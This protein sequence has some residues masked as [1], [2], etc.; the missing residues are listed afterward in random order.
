MTVTVR[1]FAL[2]GEEAGASSEVVE[3]SART[4]HGL[5]EELEK[6]HRFSLGSELVL[7]AQDDEFCGWET[8]L[9]PG[10]EVAFMPP[11]SGG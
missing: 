5:W 2:L 8:D 10:S 3:T 1:Y 9:V 11:V 7:P 6:R 4:L